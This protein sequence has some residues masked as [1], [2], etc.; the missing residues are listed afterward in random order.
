LVFFLYQMGSRDHTQ[1]V[2]LEGRHLNL[3]GHV[4]SSR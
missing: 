2:W 1:V 4:S 3:L